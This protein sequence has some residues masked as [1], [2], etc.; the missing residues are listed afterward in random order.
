MSSQPKILALHLGALGDFVLSWPALGALT[1]SHELHL[2]GRPEWAR[3]VLPPGRIYDRETARFTGL[4]GGEADE[5][6]SGWL[7]GFKSAVLFAH[8]PPPELLK[9]LQMFLPV[10]RIPTKPAKGVTMHAAEVQLKAL[11]GL[12][13]GGNQKPLRPCVDPLVK[14]TPIAAPGSGGQAKRLPLPVLYSFCGTFCRQG[15]RPLVV[16]GPVERGGF[17]AEVRRSLA[18]LEVDYLEGADIRSLAGYLA[19]AEPYL[20]ADSGVSHLAGAL[21]A[22]GWVA[23]GPSDPAVWAP[24]QCGLKVLS[25]GQLEDL[26]CAPWNR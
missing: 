23:F 24:W 21:G 3:L 7:A 9:A 6:L 25:F 5:K 13:V 10:W 4:F 8:K 17:S 14:P 16:L 18:G 22:P 11:A 15:Q 20:G 1:Q 2:W 19:A 26:A 12:G